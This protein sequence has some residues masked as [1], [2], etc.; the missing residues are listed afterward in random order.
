[1]VYLLIIS[2]IFIG[3]L[4]VKNYIEKNKKLGNQEKILKDKV[5]VTKYHNQGAFLN[6]FDKNREIL[7][8]CCGILLGLL[9][10]ALLICMP[11]K[12]KKLLK[13]GLAF[14]LGGAASNVYDRIHRGYVVDYFSFSF[15]DKLV[16]NISDFFIF[17]G[18]IIAAIKV[19]LS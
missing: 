14:M 16:F 8:V 12:G 9:S 6:L 5:I 13:L 11:Q 17:I 10:M 15:F 4:L 18:S 7:L 3:D 1:M 19:A 2:T